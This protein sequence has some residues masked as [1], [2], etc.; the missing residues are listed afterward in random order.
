MSRPSY[1]IKQFDWNSPE[2]KKA[3]RNNIL[4]SRA[5]E[6]IYPITDTKVNFGQE[7]FVIMDDNFQPFEFY[8]LVKNADNVYYDQTFLPLNDPNL[9]K[10]IQDHQADLH[11]SEDGKEIYL[12]EMDKQID[13]FDKEMMDPLAM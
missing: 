11:I 12:P 7:Q 13:T 8:S 2:Y 3:I 9:N 6:N 10:L 4:V 5:V 1:K